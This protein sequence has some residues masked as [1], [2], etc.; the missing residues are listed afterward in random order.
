M[1]KLQ[2]IGYKVVTWVGKC[3][4]D[5]VSVG[6]YDVPEGEGGN[7]GLVFDNT[8]SKQV[9]KTATFVLMT[10]PTNAPP[11]S[12]HNLQFSQAVS[13]AVGVKAS[14]QVTAV[15]DSTESLQQDLHSKSSFLHPQRPRSSHASVA[16]SHDSSNLTFYTGTLLKKRRKRGQ[17]YA[18]RFFSLDYA[19]NTLSYYRNPHSSALR[20][21]IPLSL[22]FVAQDESHREF[23]IDSGAEVWHLRAKNKK[24]YAAWKSALEKASMAV[25]PGASADDLSKNQYIA[26]QL[27]NPVE[28]A[29]WD[30]A[31]AL[32]SRVAGTRDAVR[33]LAKDTDPKYMPSLAGLSKIN[34]SS[35]SSPVDSEGLDYF[36]EEDSSNKS[37]EKLPFWKRKASS[38]GASPS[39]LFRRSVSAQL[40]VPAPMTVPPLPNGLSVPKM[41]DRPSISA[42]DEDAHGRCMEI[43]QDLDAVVAEFSALITESKQ[44]RAPTQAPKSPRRSIDSTSSEEF[45]D[46]TDGGTARSGFLTI[47]RDS[48]ESDQRSEIVSDGDSDISSEGEGIGAFDRSPREGQTSLY[49][50]KPKTLVPLP[51]ERV[52]R[53]NVIPPA[54]VAPPSLIGFLRKNVGKD[55]STIAMPVSANEPT[56]L[57]QRVAE[58]LEYSELLDS[59][60]NANEDTGERLLH[61]AAFAISMF[62]NSRVKDRAIRKPFNPMLGET[63]ELVREDKG[64]RFI[65]EKVS[66]RPVRMASQAEAQNWTFLQSPM[67]VQKFWG[68]SAEL[69]TDGRARV[70]FHG[71]GDHYSWTQAT[72]FLRNIIAGEKYVEPVGTMTVVNETTGA[73]AMATFKAGGMFAGRSEDV[74]VQVFDP[75]GSPLPLGL[76]GK[77]TSH[78]NITNS[79][80]DTG[81]TLWSV[82]PLVDNAPSR[83]GMTTF[84]AS[85][86]EITSVELGHIPV[87]DS[88]LRPDQRAA[89]EGDLDRAE[90]LKAKLEERQRGRRRVMEEHG[91]VWKPRWFT[92]T[93][94]E[95][96]SEEI[97]KLKTGKDGY[98][99]ERAKGEWTNVV[100]VLQA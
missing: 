72:S 58:Q 82:G 8:F 87:T 2:N 79:A 69:N 31:E 38:S 29:E 89:E 13:A 57:L 85:L 10:F 95:G 18:N 98:W 74:T 55:L 86:N 97:W 80:S 88:R 71:S 9:S 20:G 67:P 64:Y 53:R 49:P 68:K 54:R 66:H 12:G 37:T 48:E 1:E 28:D 59:A 61:V 15:N 19:T 60:A 43:L 77:W 62:S 84:A 24:D 46:A 91:D 32:L 76:I 42:V 83:Y 16:N 63:Y 35:T 7:Y 5:K 3:E 27:S 25:A 94:A 39:G 47:S 30:R 11:K 45:F 22:A 33:K 17:G 75:Q 65:S 90:G 52:K 21:V 50:Q 40:A 6:R 93:S 73:K 34:G 100:D 99:E 51:L 96:D 4:A 70:L 44:R 41:R 23:S 14:P 92:K 78:L 56:S 26:P 81:K 36:K